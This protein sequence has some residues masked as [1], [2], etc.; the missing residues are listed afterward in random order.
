MLINPED[1]TAPGLRFIRRGRITLTA[2][3]ME[4]V[5]QRISRYLVTFAT[6]NTSFGLVICLGMC[7]IGLPYAMLW[8][9]LAGALRF[10]P[11]AGAATAFVLP[12]IFSIAYF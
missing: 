4:E 2:R 9:F 11:Y 10:I 8:G 7:A 5:G 1:L 3:T 6:V 12:F